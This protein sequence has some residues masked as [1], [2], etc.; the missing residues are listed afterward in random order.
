MREKIQ[1]LITAGTDGLDKAA[2]ILFPPRCPL[3]ERFLIGREKYVCAD[4]AVKLPLIRQPFCLRCGRPLEDAGAEY[5]FHCERTGW[6]FDEG[7]CTFIYTGALKEALLRMKFKNHR[8]YIPFFAASMAGSG[9]DFLKTRCPDM[10]IPVP[11]HERKA[12]ERGF[13]QCA[14]IGEQISRITGIV[15]RR[16]ILI[17]GR[18]TSAQ[19]GLLPA[20]RMKNLAGAFSLRDGTLPG[21]A[22]VLL[23]DD[24]FT[25]GTTIN[26]CARVLKEGG[27]G[28]VWFLALA[29]PEI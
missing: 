28:K 29:A 12:K 24:L 17:R 16:D 7:R 4:C 9:R 15:Q 20:Q 19:K 21:G 1:R 27:A 25:T 23:V 14:L 18:Y 26:E 6:Y 13:D 10:I 5:C 22:G 3:C 2:D 8:D 11:L